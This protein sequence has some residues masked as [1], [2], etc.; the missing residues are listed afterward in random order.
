MHW[1]VQRE[2][3]FRRPGPVVSHNEIFP[4]LWGI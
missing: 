2:L 1:L 3:T 4:F